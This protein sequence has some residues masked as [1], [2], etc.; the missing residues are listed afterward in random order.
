[1]HSPFCLGVRPDPCAINGRQSAGTAMSHSPTAAVHNH[2][3]LQQ[4][5][6]LTSATADHC[7]QPVEQQEEEGGDDEGL[8]SFL[9]LENISFSHYGICMICIFLFY[10]RRL[11]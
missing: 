6:G 2:T 1:M 9:V 7:H 3:P 11:R 5:A 8:Y 4:A 10:S